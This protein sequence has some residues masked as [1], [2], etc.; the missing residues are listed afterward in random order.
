[1]NRGCNELTRVFF[2]QEN[3]IHKMSGRVTLFLAALL[4]IPAAFADTDVPTSYSAVPGGRVSLE[5]NL[6]RKAAIRQRYKTGNPVAGREKS[7]LCQGCHGESGNS[8]DPLIPRL[9]GQR[10]NYITK[11]IRDYQDGARTHEIMD[12]MATTVSD[13][14][15]ADIAAYFASQNK[16]QGGGQPDNKLGKELFLRPD[17]FRMKIA[18]INCH[19]EK[20]MGIPSPDSAFPV[21]GGQYKSY[22]RQ[23]LL[24]FRNGSRTNSPYNIMGRMTAPLTNAEINALA[25]YISV[26]R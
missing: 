23:Q 21:I 26:Q 5:V 10:S 11:Q 2:P 20:G 18:C 16:M 19:G 1:M 17:P 12:A 14:D 9:A 13:D 7:Q 24:D 3:N 25:E 22:I 15:L 8:S 6:E 4:F